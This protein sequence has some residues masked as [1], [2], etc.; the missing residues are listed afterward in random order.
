MA[1]ILLT[2]DEYNEIQ[3][4]HQSATSKIAA[5]SPRMATHYSKLAKLHADFLA[6]EDGKRATK[7]TKTT[8]NAA[9]EEQKQ[10]RRAAAL[11]VAQER[12]N[13]QQQKQPTPLN[14]SQTGRS[15]GTKSA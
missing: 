1:T 10:A 4:L 14:Q 9:I 8:I 11:Q 6:A 7:A 12:I 3:A 15:T 2:E 5:A 13:K